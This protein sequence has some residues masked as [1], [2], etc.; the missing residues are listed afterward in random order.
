MVP[1]Q[2]IGDQPQ[3]GRLALF[4]MELHAGE[5]VPADRRRNRP[6]VIDRGQT[7]PWLTAAKR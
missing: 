2:E 6:A 7:S 3:A 4:G 1:P 5:I